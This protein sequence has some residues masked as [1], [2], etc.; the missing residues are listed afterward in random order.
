[1]YYCKFSKIDVAEEKGM[2]MN[3]SEGLK[4]VMW[5]I[6]HSEFVEIIAKFSE[7]CLLLNSL[8]KCH[9]T[10]SCHT[11]KSVPSDLHTGCFTSN[12]ATDLV[13]WKLCA[14]RGIV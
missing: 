5:K 8:F 3:S 2:T 12:I 9:C 10:C 1:M 4:L 14:Q 6:D 13:S 7:N 11:N